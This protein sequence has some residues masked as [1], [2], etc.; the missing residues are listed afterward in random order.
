[1]RKFIK[2]TLALVICLACCLPILTACNIQKDDQAN[3]TEEITNSIAE[4]GLGILLSDL[5]K[6]RI[7]YPE[8]NCTLNVYQELYELQKSIKELY[9]AELDVK[10]DYYKEGSTKFKIDDYEILIGETNRPESKAVIGELAKVDDYH[11][12][13]CGKKLVIGGVSET[14][15][16]GA[17]DQLM[18]ALPDA[19][20]T[21]FYETATEYQKLG[22][23]ALDDIQ[24]N[25]VSVKDYTIVYENNAYCKK[26]A[27]NLADLI[28]TKSGYRMEVIADSKERAA[29]EILIGNTNR[30]LP[31]GVT[32]P[33]GEGSYY[34]GSDTS[35][36]YFYSAYD[37]GMTA[38]TQSMLNKIK[39]TTKGTAS[40]QLSEGE[41]TAQDLSITSMS[42]N[43]LVRNPGDRV[44]EVLEMIQ[45]HSPDTLG[46]QEASETWMNYLRLGLITE[47]ASVGIGRDANGKGEHSAIFYKKD[48]F[49][50][51]ESGTKWLSSTPDKVSKVDG[52]ICNRIFTYAIL[53]RNSDGQ[54]FMHIN[55]HTDHA[56]DSNIRL[57]QLQA[58]T[59]FMAQAQYRNIPT[60]ISGD[61]NDSYD[62]IAIQHLVKFGLENAA[63]VTLAGKN[64]PTFKT[65]IIDYF[66][67]TPN[68]FIVYNYQVDA[69]LINDI[70]PS[71]H[72]PVIVRFDLT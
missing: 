29:K 49:T 13:L 47:Y 12:K 19:T 50:L 46:V 34:V 37:Y 67:M 9:G 44:D 25:G 21:Y 10:D 64:D 41:K 62:S 32:I 36:F 5:G 17:L 3:S 18:K 39:N 52:S 7:V 61:L 8:G 58:I 28:L 54:I 27:T 65:Q 14:A 68:D 57:K 42:F 40:V 35:S 53:K 38:A 16:L 51:I 30:H 59:A 11:I 31:S 70:E 2:H 72:R 4:E 45:K 66:F 48:K 24:L 15:L 55:T 20:A 56:S 22:K 69:S 60:F 33:T 26:I 71:D 63:L 1:M 23:Y 6:Y 43:V